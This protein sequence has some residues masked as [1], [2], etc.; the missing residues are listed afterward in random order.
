MSERVC[1]RARVSSPSASLNQNECGDCVAASRTCSQASRADLHCSGVVAVGEFG[2][3]D[4]VKLE[5]EARVRLAEDVHELF[6]GQQFGCREHL[7]RGWRPRS[8]NHSMHVSRICRRRREE[9]KVTILAMVNSILG[10]KNGRSAVSG[11]LC[12]SRL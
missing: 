4:P 7:R 8:S 1:R 6:N 5:V 10:T 12:E 9:A 3:S 11:K 2:D